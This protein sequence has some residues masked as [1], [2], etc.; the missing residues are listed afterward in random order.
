[1]ANYVAKVKD[2]V[3]DYTYT[4]SSDSSKEAVGS[5]LG[6]D[7][8]LQL[9]CAE[10][11]YQDPLEPTTNTEYVAQLATF[12]QLEATLSMQ[13]TQQNSFAGDLVGKEV[14]L[15]T[16][17]ASGNS[18]TVTGRVD[19]VMY[20]NGDVMLSVNDGLYSL[21][22]LDT[23]ADSEYY[24]ASTL[25]NTFSTMVATLPDVDNITTAYKG[26]V[27]EVRSLYD[28]MTDYQK[29]FVKDDDLATLRTIEERMEDLVNLQ[30]ALASVTDSL[31]EGEEA[32]ESDSTEAA[33][34][35][36]TE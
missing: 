18:K 26:A 2:G 14:I 12:S 20:Q 1:M 22:T 27:E 29:G 4:D 8:F 36:E 16:E 9:L 3:L 25:A 32:S 15:T 17:D 35:V 13:E 5:D 19:Y 23:V 28:D 21:E 10:M 24:D 30:A 33:E 31:N 34:G 7:Q 11:Q 6:Y